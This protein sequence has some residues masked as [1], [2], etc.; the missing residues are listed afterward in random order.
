MAF[1]SKGWTRSNR[2][3]QSLA[4]IAILVAIVGSGN[5]AAAQEIV[6]G[7]FEQADPEG[8][9]ESWTLQVRGLS[10]GLDNSTAVDG[11]RALR[12]TDTG[13]AGSAL[14]KQEFDLE[15]TGFDGATLRGRIRTRG[16]VQ[17]AT[18][19]AILEGPKGP[20]FMDDMRDRSVRG[21][22]EWQEH[23][24]YIPASKEARSLTVGALV[25]GK[26]M[27]WFDDMELI[28]D[29]AG[30]AADVDVREYV[31]EA[32]SVMRENYLHADDVDWDT[33]RNR[34]LE[35][36]PDDASMA[37]AH[38]AV[39]MMIEALDDPHAGFAGSHDTDTDSKAA[40]LDAVEYATVESAAEGIALIWIPS[41][42]G[43]TAEKAQVA[44]TDNAHQ[45]LR[46]IDSPELCGWIV[47]LRDNTGGNM[48]P[49]LAAIGPIA[50]PGVL[51][52]FISSGGDEVATWSYRDGA[53]TVSENS[54]T[55]ERAA[56][57][58]QAFQPDTPGLPVAVLVSERTLSSGEATAIA[59][60]GRE[61]TRLFGS[62]TGGLATANNGHPLTDGVRIIFPIAYM[63]D[64]HGKIHH[65]SVQPDEEVA[66]GDAMG[67]AVRWLKAQ[68][69]CTD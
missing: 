38:A 66:P 12:I 18:L 34:G 31:L 58:A 23:T 45:A 20:I 68:R 35:S 48:W 33:V 42:P 26:G 47:D 21:D 53:A 65:P 10:V 32:L 6:N 62:E 5:P 4:A 11:D 52:Q 28:Q 29:Q 14:I 39:R 25:I 17:S 40:Q 9:P 59:F 36:L 49:M 3:H 24:I 8:K 15:N 60:V 41:V 30:A 46:S 7:T 43:S 51:G 1:H 16:I 37:Q 63:A 44:F 67:A 57:S 13:A 56:V 64:R 69:G 27:A 19:V 61:N 2:I 50:G 55:I 22:T 54:E